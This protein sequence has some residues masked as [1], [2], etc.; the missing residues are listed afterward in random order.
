MQQYK[1]NVHLYCSDSNETVPAH[2]STREDLGIYSRLKNNCV[3]YCSYLFDE[4]EHL[5]MQWK[6]KGFG[7]FKLQF[8]DKIEVSI[9][10]DPTPA[11]FLENDIWREAHPSSKSKWYIHH[12]DLNGHSFRS[13]IDAAEYLLYLYQHNDEDLPDDEVNELFSSASKMLDAELAELRCSA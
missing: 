3:N 13:E 7:E 12:V 5:N 4:F 2:L 11:P 1:F 10:I 9:I 6:Y 8:D